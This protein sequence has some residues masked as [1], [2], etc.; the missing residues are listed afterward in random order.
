MKVFK[1][2]ER[3]A[4]VG[5]FADLLFEVLEAKGFSVVPSRPG[6]TKPDMA[7]S[8]G[9]DGT[10]LYSEKIL[11]GVPKLCVR[12]SKACIKCSVSK[13]DK[14]RPR[15]HE[16]NSF[17]CMN[18]VKGALDKVLAGKARLREEQKLLAT[19]HYT[20]GGRRRTYSAMALNEVQVHNKK[21]THAL[22]CAVTVG[23]RVVAPLFIGDGV[24]VATPFGATGYFNAV[25]RHVFSKGFG[26][27][28]NNGIRPIA[29]IFL[30]NLRQKVRIDALRRH[31]L[32]V[33]DNFS[34]T[35][36]LTEGDYVEVEQANEPARFVVA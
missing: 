21:P 12:A 20:A 8:F 34:R 32:F 10:I 23:K 22:R 29:P 16:E 13:L 33:A 28:F 5:R 19:A 25:T 3:V 17:Y 35:I 7:V 14:Y 27:A 4:V 26:I 30:D 15:A 31:G 36:T 6:R 18:C 11:P 2:P 24:I 9:G 1:L